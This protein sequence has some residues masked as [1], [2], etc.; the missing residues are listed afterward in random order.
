MI[1]IDALVKPI[2]DERPSGTNLRFDAEN[3]L[4]GQIQKHRAELDPALDPDGRGKE[5]NWPAVAQIAEQVLRDHSKDLEVVGWLTEAMMR[6]ER[7]DGLRQGLAL[8][9][10]TVEAHWDTVHPGVDEDG[11]TLEIRA[12][13][14]SWLGSPTFLR[15]VKLCPFAPEADVDSSWL[16]RDGALRLE[17][18]TLSAERRAELSASGQ[19][20][21]EQWEGALAALSRD[22]LSAIHELLVKSHEE[23]RAIDAFCGERFGDVEPPNLYPLQNLLDE[24]RELLEARGAGQASE[25][26]ASEEAVPMPETAAP[27]VVAAPAAAGGPI[28]SRQDALKRLREVGEYFKRNEPHSPLS[29]LIARAVRWGDMSFE[30]VVRD[31]ARNADLKQIWDTL[32]VGTEDKGG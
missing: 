28:A 20:S 13:P 1:D 10:R 30:Q 27:Q 8:M 14:L 12:R 25:A 23:L 11:I 22:A 17:D 7:F 21:I 32:G 5:A 24:M 18:E 6:L 31:L 29:L 3:D 2:S 9:R 19:I 16:S 15:A 26:P 4:L